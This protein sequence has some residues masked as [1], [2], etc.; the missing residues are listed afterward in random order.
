MALFCFSATTV[1][2]KGVAWRK[3]WGEFEKCHMQ[4]IMMLPFFLFPTLSDQVEKC[5]EGACSDSSAILSAFLSPES[6]G[7]PPKTT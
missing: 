6:G 7:I 5:N 4:S 2:Y 3:K 1:E